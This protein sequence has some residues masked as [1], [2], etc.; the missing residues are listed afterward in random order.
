MK[1]VC[2]LREENEYIQAYKTCT[3]SPSSDVDGLESVAFR[4][5]NADFFVVTLIVL[6]TNATAK[7]F[8]VRTGGRT[9]RYTLPAGAVATSSSRPCFGSRAA[10]SPRWR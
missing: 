9:F 10:R 7:E 8:A 2:I 4:H 6:N 3:A 1:G 5:T